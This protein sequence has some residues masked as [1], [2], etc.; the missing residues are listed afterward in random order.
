MT[1]VPAREAAR[2]AGPSTGSGNVIDTVIAN[3]MPARARELVAKHRRE[4]AE[5]GVPFEPPVFVCSHAVGQLEGLL[6]G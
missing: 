5:L 6:D 3:L 4:C 2:P 1:D